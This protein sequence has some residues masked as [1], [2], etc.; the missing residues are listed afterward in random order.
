MKN[1]IKDI[2]VFTLVALICSL[3]IYLSYKLVGGIA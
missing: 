2:V 3:L 1:I